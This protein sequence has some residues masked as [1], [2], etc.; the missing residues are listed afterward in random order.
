[1]RGRG[2][3]FPAVAGGATAKNG[4]IPGSARK[5][6]KRN[7]DYEFD[8]WLKEDRLF[9]V[10]S[11]LVSDNRALRVANHRGDGLGVVEAGEARRH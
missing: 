8:E 2:G 6:G 4:E 1:M 7:G 10:E 9:L 11:Y 5:D 3:A